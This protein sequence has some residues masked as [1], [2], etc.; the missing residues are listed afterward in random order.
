MQEFNPFYPHLVLYDRKHF[1]SILTE[2]SNLLFLFHQKFLFLK[3]LNS[4]Q[5]CRS[6]YSQMFLRSSCPEVF[7]KNVVLRNFI[8]F[9]GKHLCQS[10]FIDKVTEH[11]CKPRHVLIPFVRY[12]CSKKSTQIIFLQHI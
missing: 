8:K 12:G 10:L 9:I 1:F 5:K 2:M 3:V 7:C 6:S 4:F 11:T